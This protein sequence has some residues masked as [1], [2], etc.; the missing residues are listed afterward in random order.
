MNG[1]Q[2]TNI[3]EVSAVLSLIPV[4]WDSKVYPEFEC[5]KHLFLSNYGFSMPY[6]YTKT[7]SVNEMFPAYFQQASYIDKIPIYFHSCVE[8]RENP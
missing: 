4:L 7:L 5:H 1:E 8:L 6:I 3:S 2:D